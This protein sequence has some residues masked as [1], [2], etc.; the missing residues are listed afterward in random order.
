MKTKVEARWRTRGAATALVSALVLGI[1][2]A[3]APRKKVPIV[4]DHRLE[5]PVDDGIALYFHPEVP[6][7]TLVLIR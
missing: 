5:E 7:A 6:E 3:L 2:T 1:Q 4:I